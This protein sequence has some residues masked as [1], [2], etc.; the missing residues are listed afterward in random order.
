MLAILAPAKRMHPASC[1]PGLEMTRP[2]QL[3]E[4]RQ[5]GELLRQYAPWQLEGLL[6][7]SPELALDAFALCRD[8]DPDAPAAPA[9]LAYRGLAY[10]HLDAASLTPGELAA[11]QDRL[12]ILSA[13]YGVLRPLDGISPYRLDFMAKLR[14]E[15]KTLYRWWGD[16]L[17][18]ELFRTGEPVVDLCSGEYSRAVTPWLRPGD[19]LVTVR[20]LQRRRGRLVTQATAAKAARGEMARWLL[21]GG[22]ERPEELTAFRWEGWRWSPELSE[23]EQVVFLWD[24]QGSGR[25]AHFL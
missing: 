1:P 13:L 20:F 7:V 6:S 18:R 22:A 9:L 3:P 10:R 2:A 14:P 15:G 8:F 4:A 24:E 11:A 21:R 5:L 17:Y 16:K 25:T 23:G 19:R 12:R